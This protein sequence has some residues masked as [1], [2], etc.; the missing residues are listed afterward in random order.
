L[1]A[2]TLKLGLLLADQRADE[3]TPGQ[4]GRGDP[5]NTEFHDG[6]G[7]RKHFL[8]KARANPTEDRKGDRSDEG[9]TDPGF[10]HEA[11]S[12]KKT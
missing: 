4:P 1:H 7:K 3:E 11:P 8:V 10:L 9:E 5:E 6:G 12:P 2:E